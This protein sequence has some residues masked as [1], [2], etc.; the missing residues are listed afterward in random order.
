MKGFLDKVTIERVVGWA[1]LGSNDKRAHRVVLNVDGDDI[2]E[3]AANRSRPAVASS[4][5]H[6]TGF[7]GFEFSSDIIPATYRNRRCEVRVYAL[8][9]KGQRTEL[10][11]SPKY[12]SW[13]GATRAVNKLFLL[14]TSR[15]KIDRLTDGFTPVYDRKRCLTQLESRYR[16][17]PDKLGQRYDFISGRLEVPTIK[18]LGLA[19]F[20]RV[21]FF[22]TPEQYLLRQ[23]AWLQQLGR[24]SLNGEIVSGTKRL[25]A[26]AQRA[27]DTDLADRSALRDLLDWNEPAVRRQFDNRQTRYLLATATSVVSQEDVSRAQKQLSWFDLVGHEE[28][29]QQFYRDLKHFTTVKSGLATTDV[30]DSAMHEFDEEILGPFIRFDRQIC[31]FIRQRITNESSE[32]PLPTR[33]LL[34]AAPRPQSVDV[35]RQTDPTRRP[36]VIINMAKH[37]QPKTLV[38]L[39]VSR[40]GTSLIAGLLRLSGVFMGHKVA[41]DSHEDAEFHTHDVEKLG[42]LIEARNQEQTTWG[43]KYPHSVEYLD[44]VIGRLRNPHFLVVFRDL[45]GVAQGFHRKHDIAMCDAIVEAQHRYAKVVGFVSKCKHPLLSI[46]YEKA[47][48]QKDELVEDLSDFCGLEL[49]AK[50]KTA[51]YNF[52]SPGN[53]VSLSAKKIRSSHS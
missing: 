21:A 24:A 26:L 40:G 20:A 19:S 28:H 43:W 13:P 46:S 47:V 30:S 12:I 37:E 7:C 11:G 18:R 36:S 32:F 45:V 16:T 23:L 51:C 3:S 41:H 52:I 17:I 2:A 25:I 8:S 10:N 9:S 42:Q 5:H 14:E 22:Y 6:A 50:Q 15:A 48:A 38:V 44:E 49:S 53:Y 1:S 4:G 31:A 29:K 34:K 35:K 39:G 33:T 27:A